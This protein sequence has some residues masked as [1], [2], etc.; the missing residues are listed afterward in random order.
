MS[1]VTRTSRHRLWGIDCAMIERPTQT[2]DPRIVPL[3]LIRQTMRS[4]ETV[5]LFRTGTRTLRPIDVLLLSPILIPFTAIVLVLLLTWF[6]L[7]LAT[8]S[9][10]VALNLIGDA[11]HAVWSRS[12][13]LR[14]HGR[15]AIGFQGR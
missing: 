8:V 1:R 2:P 13:A 10:L 14:V 12:G 7:W 9:L 3:R 15:R 11:G 4:A 5:V 6:V